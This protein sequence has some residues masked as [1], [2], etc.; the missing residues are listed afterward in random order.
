[1]VEAR[2][3][4]PARRSG[5]PKQDYTNG[6]DHQLTCGTAPSHWTDS[7]PHI[8]LCL[9]GLQGDAVNLRSP[10]PRGTLKPSKRRLHQSRPTDSSHVARPTCAVWRHF[11]R[12][13]KTSSIA[14]GRK[15]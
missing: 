6:A 9:D 13:V 11:R 12:L 1:M 8:H 10:Q 15:T 5:G 7:S 3:T 4:Q 2:L 14:H